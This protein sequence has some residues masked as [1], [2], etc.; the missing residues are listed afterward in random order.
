M[1]S[2]PLVTPELV[3]FT[4]G[5]RLLAVHAT[6]GEL[7]WAVPGRGF[8]AGRAGC[9]GE[10][11]YTAAADGFARA[12][13]L[14]TGREAWSHR[15]VSGDLH[16]VTL[17][18][19]WDDV[20]ALGAGVVLAATVSGTQALEAATGAPRWTLPGSTM[21][22][23]TVVLGDGTALFTTE[24]GLLSRVGLADGGAV[25][26]A[27]L[28]VGVQNAGLAVAGDSA[29]VVTA[30]GRLVR[31]R[32]A[33]GRDQG[34]VRYTLAQCFSAP[35]VA[36]DTLVA[37]DQDGVVHG[38]RLPADRGRLLGGA[39]NP[40]R[41]GLNVGDPQ[42]GVGLVPAVDGHQV[43]R[44]RLDLAAVAQ[45]AGV[46]AAHA[47]DARRQGLHQVGGFAVVTEHQD[48]QVDRV[49]LGIE[50]QDRG[51]VVERRHHPAAGQQRGGLLG[52]TPLGDRQRV[53]A[54]LVEAERVHAVHDDLARQL[55][56]QRGQQVTV[57]LPR[58]RGDYHAGAAGGVGV[59][60]A[61][62]AVPDLSRG[63]GGAFGASGPDDHLVP[64]QRESAG[65]AASLVPGAAEDADDES[66][67]GR[68]FALS[69]GLHLSRCAGQPAKG[70][71]PACSQRSQPCVRIWL[72]GGVFPMHHRYVD[73]NQVTTLRA[74]LAPTGWLERTRAF[75]L[76]LRKAT[77][78]PGGFLLV[79]TPD[80]EPWHLTAHLDEESR[81]SGI[82]E[83]MPTLV[84]WQVPEGAPAHLRVGLER[85]EAA[86]RGET[87]FVVSPATAPVPLLERVDDA[88]RT[89]ATIFALDAGDPELDALAHESMAIRP[90]VDAVS[91]GGA[92][93]LISSSVGE[94]GAAER[95]ER[96]E[97]GVASADTRVPQPGTAGY[98]RYRPGVRGLRDRVAR[99]LDAVSGPTGLGP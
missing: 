74:L 45:A 49:D 32:L 99:L 85:L 92:Q 12:H 25:W 27:D 2:Q 60:Q 51:D 88:R 89:G 67:H 77:R 21:Y 28:G 87:L 4:A 48:V 30:D 80:E 31:V 50:Q 90:G 23:P 17:Y 15:M 33:D 71:V 86:R 76:G 11:V 53:G 59:G 36:G 93:H 95:F 84:R 6:S 82:P 3:V 78:S 39:E 58:H 37:G 44:Q 9:D 24:R 22:P 1:L 91:F 52:R 40:A 96:G 56:G 61:L 79:G 70:A 97:F 35:A 66:V 42:A 62:D 18:S 57:A 29:W 43:R 7:A 83:L 13:D 68:G 16:R 26:Q 65:Q 73:A 10:R 63:G 72:R 98:Q 8:S 69:H 54:A 38:L 14:R 55:I 81:L 94:I 46:D 5:E 64:G 20:I 75:A 41:S 47:G 19:G 34:A